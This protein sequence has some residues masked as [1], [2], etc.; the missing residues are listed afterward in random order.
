MADPDEHGFAAALSAKL[1]T[2][3]LGN[4]LHF[5]STIDS[6]NTYA[7]RLAREGALEGTTVIADSQ[8]GGKGRLGRSWVSPP[9]VNLYLS[10]LLRPPVST[11]VAP[12][13]NL[14]AAIAVADAIRETTPLS[15]TIK[16][17][18]DVLVAEKKVCGILAEMQ[19]DTTGLR[20][21]IVG[22]GVNI[23]APLSAFPAEL[24]DKASSLLIA[25]GRTI[26]RSLLTASL[27][28]HLE[29][30]YLL[31]LQEG[32]LTLHSRWEQ[33]AA[34][35]LGTHI[36]VAVSEGTV[37]GTVLGLDKDGGLLVQGENR[38]QHRLLVGDVTVLGGY[39]RGEAR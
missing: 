10:V 3:T 16:W 9:G 25:G 21:V 23:N 34:Q 37:V 4:P 2:H 12:Q 32:F 36:S 5:F 35:M 19:T 13:L 20:A 18:N 11:A 15:P 8:S 29:K 27:L 28:T 14:V 6:T 1:A 22:I 31:W 30:F 39:N 38:E 26:D 33:Y 24:R 7:A 17:P